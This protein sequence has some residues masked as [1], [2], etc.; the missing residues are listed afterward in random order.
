MKPM[1][2]NVNG[3]DIPLPNRFTFDIRPRCF[4]SDYSDE[5]SRSSTFG[6]F[7][8]IIDPK[9][10]SGKISSNW[11]GISDELPDDIQT[12]LNTIRNLPTSDGPPREPDDCHQDGSA[13]ANQPQGSKDSMGASESSETKPQDDEEQRFRNMINRLQKRLPTPSLVKPRVP[14]I[15]LQPADPAILSAKLKDGAVFETTQLNRV[16]EVQPERK[17]GSSDSGYFSASNPPSTIHYSTPENSRDSQDEPAADTKTS[18]EPQSATKK[19]NPAAPEFKISTDSVHLPVLTPK[20]LSRG[21]LTSLLFNPSPDATVAGSIPSVDKLQAAQTKQE[22]GTGVDRMQTQQSSPI[23]SGTKA[24]HRKAAQV[25]PT[26][27]ACPPPIQHPSN[28]VLSS[29]SPLAGIHPSLS[30]QPQQSNAALPF[31]A[32]PWVGGLGLGNF[33]TFPPSTAPSMAAPPFNMQPPNMAASLGT[34]T[35]LPSMR[36]PIPPF[37][38]APISGLGSMYPQASVSAAPPVQPTI[39]LTSAGQPAQPGP[40]VDRPYFPVTTKPRIPD[41]IK[42]QQYEEYLEWR[43]ANEPGYHIKCKIRQANRVVR[44]HQHQVEPPKLEEPGLMLKWKAMAEQAKSVVGAVEA[45]RAAEKRSKQNLVVEEFKAKVIESVMADVVNKDEKEDSEKKNDREVPEK[46]MED[47]QAPEK[48]T[49]KATEDK[50]TT[51]KIAEK[52]PEDMV[53]AE[54]KMKVITEGVRA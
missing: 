2:M 34:G 53:I 23:K 20:K 5:S 32:A 40:K 29:V 28:P 39:P 17:G 25:P 21:P 35:F 7:R 44:Q 10:L 22:T 43:K 12:L 47:K 14:S 37:V 46:K 33:G 24:K 52:T 19:L 49:E 48:I 42:Q 38:P 13:A 16:T 26:Q 50:A 54:K 15:K 8:R 45:R 51:E 18:F 31:F 41:P 1:L 6:E 27:L 9:I 3:E 4:K 11:M 30:L 36:P